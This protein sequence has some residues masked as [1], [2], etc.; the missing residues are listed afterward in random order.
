MKQAMI[1]ISGLV[2]SI[3]VFGQPY[4]EEYDRLMQEMFTSEG[5]GGAELVNVDAQ[6]TF[7]MDD[8][9]NVVSLTLHQNGDHEAKKID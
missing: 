4:E 7:N 2:I 9:G 5:P 1:L 3:S 8:Q 6:I